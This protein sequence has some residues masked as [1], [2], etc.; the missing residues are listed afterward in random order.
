EFFE[1]MTLK[2]KESTFYWIEFPLSGPGGETLL[3][4]ISVDVTERK[5]IK[6]RIDV[7]ASIIELFP[8][9]IYSLDEGGI[10]Q[11][12][13]PAAAAMFGFRREEILGHSINE[14]VPEDKR[15]DM[16]LQSQKLSGAGN[17]AKFETEL[18]SKDGTRKIVAISAANVPRPGGAGYVCGMI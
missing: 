7:L 14:L 9:A 2:G 4:G 8:D 3:G 17:I 12:W 11:S 6:N 18:I 16:A 5:A 10:V 13:N 1:S 15:P